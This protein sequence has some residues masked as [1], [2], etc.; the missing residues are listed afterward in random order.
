MQGIVVADVFHHLTKPFHISGILTVL[1]HLAEQVAQNPAEVFMAGVAQERPGVGQHSVEAAH[2][3]QTHQ[4]GHLRLHAGLVVVEPPGAALLDFAGDGAV[5]L[6]APDHGADD[7]IVG[8]IQGVENGFAQSA[9]FF[10]CTQQAGQAVGIGRVVDG[11]KAGIRAEFAEHFSGVIP[12]ASEVKLVHPVPP[13]VLF[14]DGNQHGGVIGKLLVPG[15]GLSGS[16]AGENVVQGVLIGFYAEAEVKAMVGDPAAMVG[17]VGNPVCQ[18]AAHIPDR[19]DGEAD[20]LF[21]LRHISGEGFLVCPHGLIGPESGQHHGRGGGIGGQQLMGFQIVHGIIGGA[22]H[23]DVGFADNA[24]RC[25][26][27]LRQNGVAFVVDFHGVVA[28]QRL[29]DAEVALQLQMGPMIQGVAD[30]IGNGLGP[31]LEFLGGRSLTGDVIFGNAAGTHGAPLV[32]VTA[33]PNLSN[34]LELTVLGDLSGVD[35]AV[36]VKYGCVLCVVV[37]QLL[38]C[39]CFQQKVFVH[40]CFHLISLRLI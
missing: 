33:Q 32:V 22:D 27:G 8:G 7:S 24:P 9:G 10:Q 12:Q 18:C 39:L 28:V 26:I 2:G 13:G 14:P 4:A 30:E 31:F 11:I 15:D 3:A 23:L 35:V 1:H 16:C 34:V 38:R 17:K 36:I 19:V 21:Q 29:C 40:K 37:E 25:H 6:K 5:G 20:H